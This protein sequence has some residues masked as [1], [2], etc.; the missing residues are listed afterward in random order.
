[1]SLTR[2]AVA[3]ED[4]LKKNSCPCSSTVE[5]AD[6]NLS[7]LGVHDLKNEGLR[8]NKIQRIF[9]AAPHRCWTFAREIVEILVQSGANPELEDSTGRSPLDFVETLKLNTPATTVTFARRSAFESIAKTLEQFVFEEV[10]P[11]AIK[12]C[13]TTDTD[14]KE[15]L[16]E[17]LDDFSDS[18]VSARDISDE[19]I[20]DF[21]NG[22]EHAQLDKIYEQ[23]SFKRQANKKRQGK[24]ERLARWS[25]H[26]PAQRLTKL[27][28]P[29]HKKMDLRVKTTYL[30]AQPLR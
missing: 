24:R 5:L 3:R 28:Y 26:R 11:S 1:M 17:W 30:I 27:V 13:R 20:D 15:Y 23:P 19:P 7:E 18:W 16:V 2:S 21:E 8:K 9:H 4:V 6:E 10:P 29:N 22:V 25:G 12:A 14:Q